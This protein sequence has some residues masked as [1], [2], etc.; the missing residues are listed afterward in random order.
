[1]VDMWNWSWPQIVMTGWI[2]THMIVLIDRV[3]KQD[4]RPARIGAMI[5]AAAFP[6]WFIALL[7]WGG[8]FS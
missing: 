3:G 2:M 8:F 1:M 5:G 4:N 6:F 7:W